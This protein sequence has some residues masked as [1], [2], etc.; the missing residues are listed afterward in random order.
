MYINYILSLNLYPFFFPYKYFQ[1]HWSF[2]RHNKHSCLIISHNSISKVC[3]ELDFLCTIF[4]FT[5]CPS[6]LLKV[7]LQCFAKHLINVSS[8]RE[9]LEWL[10]P[11]SGDTTHWELHQYV[12]SKGPSSTQA[13]VLKAY[14]HRK[15]PSEG[16]YVATTYVTF[17]SLSLLTVPT[18]GVGFGLV[19]A[20]P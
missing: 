9:V 11:G 4:S 12:K 16:W 19:L 10:L 7:Y 14:T 18:F 20:L 3:A 8:F 17:L 5:P 2:F 1:V 13:F 6:L 15:K